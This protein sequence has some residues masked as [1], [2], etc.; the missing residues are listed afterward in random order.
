MPSPARAQ[1][2]GTL[3]DGRHFLRVAC[4]TSVVEKDGAKWVHVLPYGPFVLAVD[5]R[6]FI[7][8]DAAKIL[9]ASTP[10]VLVDWEHSSEKWDGTTRAAGWI[11]EWAIET[12]GGDNAQFKR[13]GVWGRVKWTPD[14]EKDVAEE[15]FRWLSP[16][17]LLDPETRDALEIASVALTNCP[18][19]EMEGLQ[20][21]RE[22][23][24]S[25][26]GQVSANGDKNA[27]KPETIALLLS[28]LGLQTGATDEQILESARA[29][30]SARSAGS[31]DKEVLQRVTTQ[32]GTASTQLAEANGK[33]ATLETQL[34]EANEKS[35]KATFASEVK[36]CLDE[37]ATAGKL[38][39]GMR[40][41]FEAMCSS[42]ATFDSFKT[43]VLPSLP[44]IAPPAPGSTARRAAHSN[45][46]SAETH[47]LERSTYDALKKAGKTDEEIKAAA[48]YNRAAKTKLDDEDGED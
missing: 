38:A 12:T 40:A 22:R 5:G 35:E 46:G 1:H 8:S 25:R 39:P 41:G 45:V 10:P 14:G 18:A 20:S 36:T 15:Y 31:A 11:H 33:V 6:S 2:L 4:E 24:S 27:M 21:Y 43:N 44:V 16:V 17:V 26:F 32:L 37:L 29:G 48:E 9:A 3:P 23:L 47:G 34:R 7:V 42:R 30:Q 13:P 28:A 19:L